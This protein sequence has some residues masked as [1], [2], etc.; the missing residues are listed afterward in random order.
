ML[1]PRHFQN[2]DRTFRS[3]MLHWTR[4][5][6]VRCVCTAS[7]PE[8]Q[9]DCCGCATSRPTSTSDGFT[10]S[11]AWRSIHATT[12]RTQ[13]GS[14]VCSGACASTYGVPTPTRKGCVAGRAFL[15]YDPP[16]AKCTRNL[17]QSIPIATFN[18]PRPVAVP[19]LACG[20]ANKKWRNFAPTSSHWGGVAH[21]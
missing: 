5:T 14:R 10:S 15:E 21:A 7:R 18:A 3:C 17:Q 12:R 16:F 11:P 6:D 1:L 2:L 19:S 9:W 4:S 20:M 13:R 8:A